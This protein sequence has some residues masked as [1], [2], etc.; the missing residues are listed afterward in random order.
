MTLIDTLS[1]SERG[2]CETVAFR[3]GQV[4]FQ[5]GDECLGVS[6]VMGGKIRI[7]GVSLEGKQIVYNLIGVGDMFGNNLVFSSDN[8]YRGAVTADEDGTL[9]YIRK[10]T[11]V[12]L[13]QGNADFLFAYLRAQSD[14]GKRMNSRI[15][16]LSLSSPEERLDYYLSMHK[17]RVEVKSITALALELHVQRETLSRLVNGKIKEGTLRYENHILSVV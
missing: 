11:L 1:E 13:I 5:E 17:G 15:R 4:L 16:L 14:L 10:E 9:L 7:S 8:T 3:K 12:R 6:L 2:Q